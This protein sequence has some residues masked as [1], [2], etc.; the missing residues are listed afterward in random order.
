MKTLVVAIIVALVT[1]V[2]TATA[3][4]LING[5][6][7]QKNSI[8]ANR[9]TASA[10]ASLKGQRGPQ[11][12]PGNDGAPGQQGPPGPQ[13]PAGGFDLSSIHYYTGTTIEMAPGTDGTATASCPSGSKATGGGFKSDVWYGANPYG[14]LYMTDEGPLANGTG[15]YIY[16]YNSASATD[17]ADVTAYAVCAS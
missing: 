14:S 6:S 13:G 16:L 12:F 17:N 8:P 10:R 2:G 5:R 11:G 7:I 3:S 4:S 1:A 15:W 9:L